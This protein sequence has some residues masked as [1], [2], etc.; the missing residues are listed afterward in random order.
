MS[1]KAQCAQTIIDGDEDNTTLGVCIAIKFLFV[2]K[3]CDE[4]TAM[5][6]KRDR[7][8]VTFLC[9]S[10]FPYSQLETVLAHHGIALREELLDVVHIAILVDDDRIGTRDMG[11]LERDGAEMISNQHCVPGNNGLR[12]L[13]TQFANR[14][15]CIGDAL[16]ND[17]TR[18][19]G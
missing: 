16:I 15:S 5:N 12:C 13:P 11:W 8:L 1:Q 3:A 2:A 10:W 7:Q 4:G 14:R 9:L 6:P 17:D 18:R 19:F